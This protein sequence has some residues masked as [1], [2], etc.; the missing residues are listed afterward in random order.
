[1]FTLEAPP[2]F[3][4]LRDDLPI[5]VY[6]RSLP[7]W[8]QDGA[9]YFVTFRLNDVIPLPQQ[10]LLNDLKAHWRREHPPPHSQRQMAELARIL[11]RESEKW[12]DAG[13]GSCWEESYD[14]I[15]RDAEHLWRRL[16][17]IGRNGAKAGLIEG[18]FSGW[19]R[20]EWEEIGWRFED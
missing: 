13:L 10:R 4:G 8:R 18:E 11:G 7:H 2:G 5:H 15:V 6:Q 9:T 12:L 17:C 14:R 3:Q 19:V 1:M 16:Q 20:P